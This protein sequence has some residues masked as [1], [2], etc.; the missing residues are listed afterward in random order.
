[1]KLKRMFAISALGGFALALG[2]AIASAQGVYV[3]RPMPAPLAETIPVAPGSAYKWVPGHWV[4][5]GADWFWMNG[6]YVQGI[7]VP[8]MPAP[9]ME[10]RPPAPS[11]QHYWVGGHYGWEGDRWNWR[12]GAWYRR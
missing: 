2:V 6:H 7:A 1:M 5:R 10:V 4:W 9:V 3:D 8:P 12:Q 11:P